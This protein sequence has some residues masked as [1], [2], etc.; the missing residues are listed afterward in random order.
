MKTKR[1]PTAEQKEKAE[2]RRQ[3][4]K[5]LVTK[6]AAMSDNERAAFMTRRLVINTDGHTLSNNNQILLFMQLDNPSIVAGFQ[7]WR[8]AGRIVR[9]GEHGAMI[10]IPLGK[11]NEQ[12]EITDEDIRFGMTTVF[13]ISQ[14]EPFATAPASEEAAAP[15]AIAA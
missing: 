5:E 14:T 11:K 15:E 1:Q 4:F 12:G 2:A 6:V 8:K 7:Q 10:W 9:K 13:D 3:Y